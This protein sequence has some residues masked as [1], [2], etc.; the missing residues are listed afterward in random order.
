MASIPSSSELWDYSH[1]SRPGFLLPG[2]TPFPW[3]A[4]RVREQSSRAYAWTSSNAH[5][6]TKISGQLSGTRSLPTRRLSRHCGL[7]REI[8]GIALPG[9][10][11]AGIMEEGRR[12]F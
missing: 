6:A 7:D 1:G 11:V 9:Y 8:R 10:T 5:P 2:A 3:T 4:E 12:S